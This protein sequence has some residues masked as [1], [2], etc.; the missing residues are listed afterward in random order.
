MSQRNEFDLTFRNK[1]AER[2]KRTFAQFAASD[3]STSHS[4]SS[5]PSSPETKRRKFKRRRANIRRTLDEKLRLQ[6]I[7]QHVTVIDSQQ[8]YAQL[9]NELEV[10]EPDPLVLEYTELNPPLEEDLNPDNWTFVKANTL[11]E[12]NHLKNFDRPVREFPTQYEK[13]VLRAA[14]LVADLLELPHLLRFPTKDALAQVPYKPEKFAGRVYADMGLKTRREADSVAQ[15]DAEW[16]WDKLMKGER[17]QPHD[18]RLGGRGKVTQHKKTELEEKPPAV[19]R[20]ILM[21]SHRDLKILG[22]TEKLLTAAWLGDQYPISVGMSWYH[23]GCTEFVKRFMHFEEYYCFDARKYDAYLDPWL[24]KIAINI[25]REQFVDGREEEYDAYWDF[26]FESL[27][28]APIYRDDG[29]RLQKKVGTTSGHSHNTLLQSICTLIVGYGVLMALNP[30]LTDDQIREGAH[31]ESLGD[32]N[33]QGIRAPLRKA[34]VEEAAD[35]AWKIFGIDWSGKKSF[36]TSAVL[37]VTPGAFQGI[38]YLGKYFRRE[39]YPTDPDPIMVPIPYRPFRETYLRLLY[40]EYGALEADQTWLRVLGNYL[41]AAGNPVTERWLQG[42][43][44]WLEPRVAVPPEHWPNS[45]QRMVSRDYSGL[46]LE[47]PKPERMSYDQWR[48]LVLL[49][50]EDYKAS[51][52]AEEEE[53]EPLVEIDF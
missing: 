25:C 38:Q 26:V 19:G 9:K 34:T 35:L 47:V 30:E 15:I 53:D 2:L 24:I 28:E 31:M 23:Q 48:D 13:V 6:D 8:P 49:S 5:G 39:E 10:A 52:K 37:D 33:I 27:V 18:V 12:M 7:Y 3:P 40:P 44:D 36:A 11:V 50:R 51:W 22:T 14:N 42:F 46:G 4:G 43:L 41:D 20:L 29:I 1:P 17:V 16:A 45:F 21:L 32:D